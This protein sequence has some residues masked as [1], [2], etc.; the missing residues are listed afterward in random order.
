MK[1]LPAV[2]ALAMLG[3]EV[4]ACKHAGDA[5]SNA[6]YN[7]VKTQCE[8]NSGVLL[9]CG[10]DVLKDHPVYEFFTNCKKPKDGGA[11]CCFLNPKQI[12]LTSF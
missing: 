2:L 3:M 6:D 11:I 4:S 5:C 7:A 1:F 12:K 10:H 8:C 9:F